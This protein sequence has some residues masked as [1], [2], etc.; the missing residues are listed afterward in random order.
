MK[1]AP[2]AEALWTALNALAEQVDDPR[3]AYELG[4]AAAFLE[5]AQLVTADALEW[6]D[7]ALTDAVKALDGSSVGAATVAGLLKVQADLKALRTPPPRPRRP[8]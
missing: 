6:A 3:V 5:V 8:S 7:H 1:T 2:R 4:N